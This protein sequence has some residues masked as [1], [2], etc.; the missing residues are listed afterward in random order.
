M[1]F[2]TT[3]GTAE[4]GTDYTASSGSL[5]FA[6]TAGET[7]TITVNISDDAV[8]ERDETFS[9]NLSN[10]DSRGRNVEFSSDSA[11]GTI[12]ND[13]S[14]SVSI[15][16]VLMEEGNSGITPFSFVVTPTGV[17]DAS[18]SLS[19]ATADGNAKQ[20]GDYTQAAGTLTFAAGSTDP[21]TITVN[22]IGDEAVEADESFSVQLTLADDMGRKVVVASNGLVP[23]L[24]RN[25]DSGDLAIADAELVEGASGFAEM[26][27]TVTSST[28]VPGGFTVDFSTVAGTADAADFTGATGTLSFAGNSGETKIIAVPIRGDDVVELDETFTV[29]LSN[30]QAGDRAVTLGDPSAT[31]TITNDDTARIAINDVVVAEGDSGQTVAVFTL[32]LD[33]AVDAAVSVVSSIENIT[34][35]ANDIIG[36]PAPVI[37]SSGSTAAQRLEVAISPDGTVELDETYFVNLISA[38]SGGRAV[39]FS[40]GQGL[41]TITND[42]EAVVSLVA[43]TATEGDSGTGSLDVTITVSAAFEGAVSLQSA[44]VD[45]SA[46]AG[47]DYTLEASPRS[48][49]SETPTVFQVAILSDNVA[50]VEEAFTILLSELE[51]G[52]L[53]ITFVS[54]EATLGAAA[55][56]ADDDFAPVANEDGPIR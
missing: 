38:E 31:G 55:T 49:I 33:T 1:D 16:G 46:A 22:V 40:D 29:L 20:P 9:V 45:G 39:I 52:G 50:E 36:A 42:D 7:R 35:S 23:G 21:Q 14:V 10:I 30:V 13:D 18:Y 6:G 3:N 25:D 41:G 47:S 32:T 17:S 37:F 27:F 2:A 28:T 26:I 8:S 51:T 4:T 11:T 5:T 34:T 12:L 53:D 15:A 24:I 54:G 48:L 56:I 19:Y 44:A 43:G